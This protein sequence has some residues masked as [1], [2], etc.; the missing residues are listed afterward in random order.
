M[1]KIDYQL[2]AELIRYELH[3]YRGLSSGAA[4]VDSLERIARQF[5]EKASVNKAAFLKAC[6]IE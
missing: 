4:R 3:I 6:G 5:A 2:L 1:R